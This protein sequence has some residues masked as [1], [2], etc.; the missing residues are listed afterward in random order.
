MVSR[1]VC[2]ETTRTPRKYDCK[3]V[4]IYKILKSEKARA[5]LAIVHRKIW[6]FWKISQLQDWHLVPTPKKCFSFDVLH[7][8]LWRGVKGLRKTEI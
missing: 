1:G 2:W 6:D 3:I 4:S 5:T 7:K 8:K